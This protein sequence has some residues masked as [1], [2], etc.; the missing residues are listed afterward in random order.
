M[1]PPVAMAAEMMLWKAFDAIQCPTLIVRGEHSDLLSAA[2]AAEMTQ[3]NP[4][5]QA[6]EIAGV[7]HAPTFMSDDQLAI[8]DDFL[9]GAVG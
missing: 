6:V 3:R 1:S 9:P 4:N 7:G 5:A 2:T 8:A